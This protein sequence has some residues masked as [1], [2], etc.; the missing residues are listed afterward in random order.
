MGSGGRAMFAKL[1]RHK[2]WIAGGLLLV[3]AGC[4]QP[5]GREIEPTSVDIAILTPEP[6]AT[7]ILTP[8]ATAFITPLPPEGFIPPTDTPTPLPTQPPAP[9]ATAFPMFP[10]A[11]PTE[12]SPESPISV[13][14]E[15]PTT[16]TA[17]PA[18]NPCQHTVQPREWLSKIAR[19]YNLTNEDFIR[20][21][22]R[23]RIN[24]DSLQPGDVLI[25]PG[26][27]P[28]VSSG[29]PPAPPAQAP[30][31]VDPAALPTPLQLTER[32]YTVVPGD[33]LGAIAR[34]FGITVQQL[35]QAN[36]LLDTDFIRVGQQL[37]I[38]APQ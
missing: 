8:T 37:R 22:P 28:R 30:T 6:T 9:T 2:G 19:M 27:A 12:S 4:F 3:A 1:L 21:N 32:I 35:R 5:A 7:P 13:P 31:P 26:C 20:V 23:L 29:A 25:V 17:L 15:M 14:T 24:P 33:T 10:E 16:P 38:P 11:A 18:D 36:G 34:K